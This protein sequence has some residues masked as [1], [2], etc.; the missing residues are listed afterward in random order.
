MSITSEIRWI[1][2]DKPKLVT[3]R[4][5]W[6]AAIYAGPAMRQ[7][8]HIICE[9]QFHDLTAKAGMHKPLHVVIFKYNMPNQNPFTPRRMLYRDTQFK[10]LDHAIMWT[11]IFIK[12][13][14]AWHPAIL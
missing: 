9:D 8:A 10:H 14:P 7:A 13:N 1:F 6:P 5:E 11:Q 12:Q 4:W 2:P 3:E